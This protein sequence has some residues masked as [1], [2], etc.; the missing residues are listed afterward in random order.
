M[1][2]EF[3]IADKSD[4]PEIRRLIATSPMPGRIDVAFEREPDYFLGSTVIGHDN[5]VYI[6]RNKIDGDIAL[7]ASTATMPRFLNRNAVKVGYLGQLRVADTYQG[8]FLPLRAMG[9]LR[10]HEIIAGP[11]YYYS[12]V[13]KENIAARRI[14]GEHPRPGF[15]QSVRMGTIYT[16]GI[17]V[18][19]QKKIKSS[20]FSIR[21]GSPVLLNGIIAF[22]NREGL[23]KQLFPRYT[24]ED[25]NGN[26]LTRGFKLEDLLVLFSGSEIIATAGF[27][28]QE[29]YKQSVVFSYSKSLRRIKPFYNFTA[30]VIAPF[31]GMHPLP[32]IGDPIE[33]GYGAFICIKDNDPALFR[34]LLNG[35]YNIAAE[36]KKHY[37]LI[38]LAENDPL[39]EEAK[40]YRHI[41]YSSIIYLFSLRKEIQ[42]EAIAGPSIPYIEIASL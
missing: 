24:V 8:H 19:K 21:R 37:L 11:E 23:R 20:S 12:V 32:K 22:L 18:G 33:Y 5:K 41:S 39:L 40:K 29:A 31:T 28:D 9:F 17:A 6:G 14:F 16:A 36:R 35:I 2:F 34:I 1:K 4:D 7:L 15:P 27:W 3:S 26:G 38:G 10:E 25:F 13:S 30:K 42:K